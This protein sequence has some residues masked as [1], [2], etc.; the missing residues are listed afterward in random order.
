MRAGW[1]VIAAA[2]CYNPRAPTGVP[3]DPATDACPSGQHCVLGPGGYAC[4]ATGTAVVDGPPGVDAIP[5]RDGD[6][7]PDAI[8]KCPLEPGSKRSE[9]GAGC[10]EK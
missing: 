7:V 4:N 3:C 9:A 2:G 1:V 6:G 8:D 5:D 10:P